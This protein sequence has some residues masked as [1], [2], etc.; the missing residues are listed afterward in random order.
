MEWAP[1]SSPCAFSMPNHAT[2]L[3][4]SPTIVHLSQFT[5]KSSLNLSSRHTICGFSPI[6]YRLTFP[7]KTPQSLTIISAKGY[8]MKTHKVIEEL[9]TYFICFLGCFYTSAKRFQVMGSG[10][11]MRRAGKQHLLRKKNTKR[12]LQLSNMYVFSLHPNYSAPRLTNWFA[13]LAGK[14]KL[15][16]N[17]SSKGDPGQSEYGGLRAGPG[18]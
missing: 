2:R 16:T 9:G 6:L 10:K 4:T 17:G 14:L 15:N 11:I 1:H 5:K 8:K 12:N 7:T 13:P 18:A 3:R